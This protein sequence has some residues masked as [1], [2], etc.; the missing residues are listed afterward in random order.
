MANY[1]T[2][3]SDKSKK[4]AFFLCLF[5]GMLGFHRFYVGKFGS[6]FLYMCTAGLCFFGWLHDLNVILRGKFTDNTGM[7]LRH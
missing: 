6:G 7:Y 2:P 4:V 3:T 5:G 1:V